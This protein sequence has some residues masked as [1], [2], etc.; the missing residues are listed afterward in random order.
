MGENK[1]KI[2]RRQIIFFLCLRYFSSK[3]PFIFFNQTAI[4]N[5]YICTSINGQNKQMRLNLFGTRRII[6]AYQ[7]NIAGIVIDVERK[8]IKSLRLIVYPPEGK[9]KI[10]APLLMHEETIHAFITAKLAWIQKH[11]QKYLNRAPQTEIHFARGEKHYLF[12]APY[13]LNVI[14]R[15][16]PPRVEFTGTEITLYIKPGS[17]RLQRTKTIEAWYR[18]VLKE[19]AVPL[20][21]K[22][23]NIIGVSVNDFGI[24]KMKTRWGSCNIR[25]K[26]VWLNLELARRSVNCLD[27]IILHEL[28]HLLERNH[29]AKF[30]AHMDRFMPEW[31]IYNKELKQIPGS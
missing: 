28:V 6:K 8:R 13:M 23:E 10:T 3:Y 31:R 20:I 14:E 27:F 11:K 17:T 29:N 5:N 26:R 4:I 7:I 15:N 16:K 22:W 24:K 1:L 9:V 19:K 2:T 18:T 30:K 12:G 21:A 25:A